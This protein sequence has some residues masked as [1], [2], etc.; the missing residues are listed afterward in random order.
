[1]QPIEMVGEQLIVGAELAEDGERI[2]VETVRACDQPVHVPRKVCRDSGR[3]GF[4]SGRRRRCRR[5]SATLA[6]VSAE[7]DFGAQR[8]L[9]NS[10]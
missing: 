4:R 1:M 6:S 8:R 3:I 9:T 2:V 7:P 10:A 5:S